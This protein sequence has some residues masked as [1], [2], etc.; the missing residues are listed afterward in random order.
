MHMH[1]ATCITFSLFPA[2]L[3]GLLHLNELD[4]SSNNLHFI[5]YGVLED[6]YFL[7]QLK[8]VGNPWMCDYRWVLQLISVQIKFCLR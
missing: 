5:M 6:L 8:L 4:L 3:Y 2:S 7:S 1:C